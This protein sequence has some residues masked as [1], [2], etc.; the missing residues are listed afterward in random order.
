MLK[1]NEVSEKD[2]KALRY[3]A[4]TKLKEILD[5]AKTGPELDEEE[6]LSLLINLWFKWRSEWIH[7]NAVNNYNM[8]IN[9]YAYIPSVLK[10]SYISHL[11]A[12]IETLI[13]EDT[14]EK[15]HEVMVNIQYQ[16]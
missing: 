1:E 9:G 4:R 7:Y 8:V 6:T 13:P 2:S 14:L 3:Y 10:S 5:I 12:K 16:S 11:I 15:I